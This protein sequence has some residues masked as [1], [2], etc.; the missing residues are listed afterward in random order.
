MTIPGLTAAP[1]QRETAHRRGALALALQEA[2][3][4]TV[5]LRA[6]RQTA[7]DVTAF[8]NHLKQLLS[9]A[10]EEAQREG[11][12]SEDIKLAIYPVV[13][14][15]DESVLNSRHPMFADWPRKP[16]QEEVFGGHTGGEI[17]FANLGELLR[18]PDSEDLADVL[19]VY[20]LCLLL[21]FQGRY[22]V[23]GR[24][25]L[26]GVLAAVT[27]KITRIRGANRALSPAGRPPSAEAIPIGRDPWI[28]RLLIAAATAFTIALLLFVIFSASLSARLSGLRELAVFSS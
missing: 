3:T 15:I 7:A 19:E 6:N 13:V 1:R 2:L 10:H 17:F 12:R 22:S 26:R 25:E 4:A 9:A 28:R 21:G 11:Y 14:F 8:R 27:D 5:R 20:H 24:G 23:A 16:L 18:R